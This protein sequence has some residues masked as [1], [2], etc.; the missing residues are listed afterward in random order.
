VTVSVFLKENG[1]VLLS[2]VRAFRPV[3]YMLAAAASAQFPELDKE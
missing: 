1:Y 3:C 2:R